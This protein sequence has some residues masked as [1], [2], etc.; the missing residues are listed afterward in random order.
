MEQTI[1]TQAVMTS[2]SPPMPGSA[3]N[4]SWT[5]DAS[6]ASQTSTNETVW[7]IGYLRVPVTGTFTFTVKT[8]G[9]A[10]LFLSTND[11]RANK[12]KIAD[13]STSYQSNAIV[14]QNETK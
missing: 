14:L 6:Y 8:N 13:A 10:A 7:M 4:L 11:D 5:D 1:V 3:A 2:T 12:T 9:Y